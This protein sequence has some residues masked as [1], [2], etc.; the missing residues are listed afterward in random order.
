[1]S[2]HLSKCHIVGNHMSRLIWLLVGFHPATQS[3]QVHL[4]IILAKGS[5]RRKKSIA[6][7]VPLFSGAEPFVHIW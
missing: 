7:S 3:V 5:D 2:L 1:M 4:L 6:L